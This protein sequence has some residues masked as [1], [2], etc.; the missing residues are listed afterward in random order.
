VGRTHG[1][2]RRRRQAR[3][4]P[5][6]VALC[7]R[8]WLERGWHGDK[9]VF[10]ASDQGLDALNLNALRRIDPADLN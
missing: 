8:G 4:L 1:W 9:V 2:A 7:E 3:Y 10:G 6:A 5:A